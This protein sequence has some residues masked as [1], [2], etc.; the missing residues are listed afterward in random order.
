LPGDDDE[1]DAAFDAIGRNVATLVRDGDTL[2]VG[3][4]RVQRV[5]AAL[6]GRCGLRL[7]TGAITT[8]LLRLVDAGGC[9]GT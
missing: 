6:A 4:G 1:A 3:V 9:R 5:L 7:H 8:P 2:E